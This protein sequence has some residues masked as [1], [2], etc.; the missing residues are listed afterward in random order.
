MKERAKLLQRILEIFESS[1]ENYGCPRVYAQLRAEGWTCNYKVVEELM[2]MNEIRA[3]RRRSHVSTTNSKHNYPI[4]PNVLDRKFSV[5][6]PD[7]VWV[8]DIT[9]INTAQGW[10]YLCVCIDLFSRKVVGWSMADHMKTKLV[11]DAFESAQ[12]SRGRPPIVFHSD[13]GVQYASDRFRV[14]LERLGC[15]QSM[16][17]KGD[18]WDNAVAE[19]FFASLKTEL[20]YRETYNTR[21]EARVAIFEYIE[22]FYN[23]QRIHSTLGY[24]TP[25]EKGL[26][27]EKAA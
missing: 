21:I 3:R 15:I 1:R 24:L 14:E 7:E 13:R 17:G 2:R 16:S 26:K 25:E 10:L 4:A 6:E 23:K 12:V 8:S 19:S 27:G 22:I 18:C 5:S 11:L 20:I 9:Y